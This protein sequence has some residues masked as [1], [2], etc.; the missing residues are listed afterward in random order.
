MLIMFSVWILYQAVTNVGQVWYSFGWEAQLLETGFLAI[1]LVP[2]LYAKDYKTPILIVWLY[3]WLVLRIYLGA[4]LIKIRGDQCWRDLTCMMFHYETTCVPNPISWF[5]HQLP[6]EWHMMEVVFNHVIQLCVPWL[7]L[8]P[9]QLRHIGALGVMLEM[10]L[11][12]STGNYGFLNHLT[13]A[14]AIFCFDDKAFAWLG[15]TVT[16]IFERPSKR[17]KQKKSVQVE[18]KEG[19]SFR[20]L[21]NVFVTLVVVY[22]SGPVVLNLLSE[23]QVMNTSFNSFSIV[24][25]YG[26]FGSVGKVRQEII[27]FGSPTDSGDNDW[28]EYEFK[29]KPGNTT[30]RPCFLAPYHYRLDWLAWFAGFQQYQQHPW[31]V[32]L[33]LKLLDPQGSDSDPIKKLLGTNPFSGMNPPRRIKIDRYIYKYSSFGEQRWWTREYQGSFLPPVTFENPQLT[34]FINH[35][36]T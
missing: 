35:H 8:L 16:S 25:T 28:R 3:R 34:A 13:M 19:W 21:L 12:V 18:K 32:H 10:Q 22:M 15:T 29:C 17:K 11:I 4:G 27:V 26:A 7:L 14:P 6:E 24:N 33:V 20:Q 5:M 1:F 2:F 36:Y 31:V 30:K 9:R 23:S